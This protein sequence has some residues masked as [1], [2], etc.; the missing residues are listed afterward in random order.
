MEK[1][2]EVYAFT[3]MQRDVSV[4]KH[5]VNF[6]YDAR[7]IR[8]TARDKD[9]LLSVTNE[10]GTDNTNV[11]I[12]GE[13]LGH[14]LLDRYLVVFSK[15]DGNNIEDTIT[16]IDLSGDKL[17][18]TALFV[19]DLEFDGAIEAIG[20][21]ENDK[22]QKVYWTDGDNQPRMINIVAE[23][24]LDSYDD[25]HSYQENLGYD[26]HSF[27]FIRELKLE[28]TVS[29]K[30]ELGASG[31]FAPGVI[32]YAFTYYNKYGQ[33][34][35]IFYTSPLYYISHN[36]RGGSPEDTRIDNAFK[37]TIKNP[38]VNFDYIRIYSI[39]RTS[40]NG[41][42]LVKRIQDIAID[43]SIVDDDDY[44]VSFLD[45]G[46]TGDTIDPTELL[47]KGGEEISAETIAQKDGTLFL[48][49][50][51][52]LRESLDIDSIIAEAKEE[53]D[54]IEGSTISDIIN[55]EQSTRIIYPTVIFTGDNSNY[56]NQLT[57]CPGNIVDGEP[58][59]DNSRTVPCAGFKRG[60]Y[61]RCGI[62][63]QHKTG[64]WSDPLY[65]KDVQVENKPTQ[66][67]YNNSSTYIELP[68]LNAKLPSWVASKLIEKDYVKARAV[69][70]F[71]SPLD[72]VTVCQ[73]VAC[74]TLYTTE[75]STTNKDLHAQSSW[76]FRPL[77]NI[78]DKGNANLGTVAPYYDGNHGLF[79]YGAIDTYNPSKIRETEIQGVYGVDEQFNISPNCATFNSPDIEFDD[80]LHIF[81]YGN[82]LYM[83]V[84]YV[85]FLSTASS[86]NI[87]TETPTLSNNANGIIK[88]S[89]EDSLARGIIAGLFYEDY[90]AEDYDIS[91]ENPKVRPYLPQ[92]SPSKWLIYP[93]HRTGSLN[94][95]V[96]RPEGVGVQSSIL[97]KKIISN[98]RNTRTSF[99]DE[100]E[101]VY[102]ENTATQFNYSP[103]IFSSNENTIVKILHNNGTDNSR[104]YRGNI[105]T[106]LSPSFPS[107]Y[108]FGYDGNSISDKNVTTSF[109]TVNW[110]KVWANFTTQNSV[111]DNGLWKFDTNTNKW[112]Y[113][114]YGDKK[115]IGDAY[116]GLALSRDSV[117][118]KYK[119]TPHLVLYDNNSFFPSA[120][121]VPLLPILEIR[122]SETNPM[123]FGG[124]S[125][126]ALKANVWIPCGEPVSLSTNEEYIT[127]PYDYGDTYF[128][129]WDCL[130][131]Y[132]FS[133]DDINQIVEIG[134]FMLETHVNIDGRYDRNRGQ[135]D[136]TNMS[137]INFN[138][139]NPVYSQ[140][141]NFFSYKILDSD[142]YK[143]DKFPNQITW[144][145]E[146][147]PGADVDLW[148]NITLASTYDMDGSKGQIV[149]LN[150]WKDNIYCFQNKGISNILFNS[151]VQI[152]TS[153][154]VPIEISNNYKVDGYRYLSDGIGC[155]SRQL[156][157]ESP[158]GIY[159]IDSVSSNLHH[160][161]N[162]IKDVATTHN[163]T[164]WFRDNADNLERLVYDELHRDLYVV[165]NDDAL[166]FSELLDQFTSFYDYGS[167][168]LMESYGGKVFSL[169]NSTLYRMFSGEY[170]YL[171]EQQRPW[172]LTFISNGLGNNASIYDKTFTN[173]EFRACVDGDGEYAENTDKFTPTMPLDFIET[174]DEYQR[175]IAYL[176]I[177]NGHADMTHHSTDNNASLKRKFR[178][179]RC[180]IPRNNAPTNDGRDSELGIMRKAKPND[181]MRNP[182]LY[183]RLQKNAETDE[184]SYLKRT[185]LH[186]LMLT[187]FV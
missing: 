85:Q 48:G 90:C 162:G 11:T 1:K 177:R 89:F 8:L 129:R 145:K 57:S 91:S 109:S 122:N 127:V 53:D 3:G 46:T 67:N 154:G 157:K 155:N 86:I 38:D 119:S 163:M 62:Q 65:I 37:I 15:G 183:V 28:E 176:G 98:L 36:D 51:K 78:A 125:M 10:R 94:N 178:I 17:S 116:N 34:S 132:P 6:L 55:I 149:S 104:I 81:N 76:F 77:C 133:Q 134:S 124:D 19:G 111:T 136:N 95:D 72:R 151:R 161:A 66:Y 186:N 9:T 153:D 185:E 31:M 184:D 166:C 44:S 117:R 23:S 35:N 32:Q 137:P 18:T 96:E 159:F 165:G 164:S 140:I 64:K 27:D 113:Q 126:D 84:G 21:Y 100:F 105:D 102:G 79:Y 47:Y 70:V 73:G 40:L 14:C 139:L 123:R 20:S 108:Y 142:F 52:F 144:T 71:P 175:G 150:T 146:K 156:I 160:I 171:F 63:F 131:T 7:N 115:T 41:T 182:W 143:L 69:V 75:H 168:S 50:I 45:T 180:D 82:T 103:V 152:P 173:L 43:S 179:W 147:Q 130:K 24:L 49:N 39:Q 101:S 170:N 59:K 25:T 97:K 61:Y 13:Y 16:R 54:S 30:K 174:W 2:N 60:D 80:T 56:A 148:T 58:I 187:Y 114:N 68:S 106:L 169:Y 118:M 4:S 128:Q 83:N 135:M 172:S 88:K 33:E 5:P 26:E 167:M 29:I 158:F 87:Q 42:P 92:K 12:P 107:P 141:D 121:I 138:L 22:I 120:G 74:P 181:R 99:E 112:V 93:W 110:W